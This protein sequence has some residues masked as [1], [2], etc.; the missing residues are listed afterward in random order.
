VDG[1]MYPD[2]KVI[3]RC[4]LLRDCGDRQP[5]IREIWENTKQM[6]VINPWLYI[7]AAT[8]IILILAVLIIWR[9]RKR[10]P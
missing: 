3:Q 6:S 1:I 2:L 4:G 8:V 5:E 10:K 7:C 9:I